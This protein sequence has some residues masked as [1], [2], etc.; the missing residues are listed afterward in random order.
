M[1]RLLITGRLVRLMLIKINLLGSSARP[2]YVSISCPVGRTTQQGW[3]WFQDGLIVAGPAEG[4]QQPTSKRR[5]QKEAF[6]FIAASISWCRYLSRGVMRVS[7]DARRQMSPLMSDCHPSFYL[8]RSQ[9]RTETDGRINRWRYVTSQDQVLGDGHPIKPSIVRCP[10][11][12]NC[13]DWWSLGAACNG[14]DTSWNRHRLQMSR[15]NS[16]SSIPC[17]W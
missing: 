10:L 8:P 17:D 16:H 1:D 4:R 9:R 14:R 5:T 6:G 2:L 7:R 11:C 12:N 3:R 13:L 15:N